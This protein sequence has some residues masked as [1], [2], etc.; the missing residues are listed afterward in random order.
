MDVTGC[1]NGVVRSISTVQQFIDDDHDDD[2]DDDGDTDTITEQFS[3]LGLL[4][5]ATTHC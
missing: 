1:Q 5:N 2:D 3:Q 4:H